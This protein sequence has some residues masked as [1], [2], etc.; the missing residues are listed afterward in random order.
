[1]ILKEYLETERKKVKTLEDIIMKQKKDIG[2]MKE[3][4]DEKQQP[5][6]N[7]EIYSKK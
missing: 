5:K 7:E 4:K 2:M 3:K 6:G 1:M